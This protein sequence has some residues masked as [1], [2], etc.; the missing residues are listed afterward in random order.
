MFR[1]S[2]QTLA[3]LQQAGW[4]E[5]YRYDTA[6]YVALLQSHGF[7]VHGAAL[8]FMRR[9]GGLV[10]NYPHPRVPGVTEVAKFLVNDG[11]RSGLFG[12][13]EDTGDALGV[14]LCA[15]G[16]YHT[17]DYFLGMD[18]QGIVYG[19][20]YTI[21]TRLGSFGEE[22]IENICS[23]DYGKDVGHVPS[24]YTLY[25]AMRSGLGERNISSW[26]IS[27]AERF[28]KRTAF[29]AEQSGIS[30]WLRAASSQSARVVGTPSATWPSSASVSERERP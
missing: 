20:G 1:F 22:A 11:D 5:A 16:T 2:E 15:I 27:G 7:V 24:N 4:S 3:C 12:Y 6:Q 14:S 25:D 19:F 23:G 30:T 26:I 8:V 9:F 28:S 13:T 21:L 17:R 10:F 29:K 18:A